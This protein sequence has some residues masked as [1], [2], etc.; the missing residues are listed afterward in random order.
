MFNFFISFARFSLTAWIGAASMFVLLT[1]LEILS[2][3][4][5]SIIL[6]QLVLTRFPIFYSVTLVLL[7]M[8][9]ICGVVSWRLSIS[10][11]RTVRKKAKLFTILVSVSIIILVS[12]YFWVYKELEQMLIPLGSPRPQEFPFY[13]KLTESLNSAALLINLVASFVINWPIKQLVEK[14]NEHASI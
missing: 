9:W 8:S 10:Q 3:Q 4:F 14:S 5:N 7:A 12:D 1:V 6:D 13:H 11:N 2:G